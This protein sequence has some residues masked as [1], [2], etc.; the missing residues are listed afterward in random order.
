MTELSNFTSDK[1]PLSDLLK[2]IQAGKTQLPDFQRGWVWDNDHICSLLASISL[3]FPIGAV[4]L[5]QTGGEAKFKPRLIEG[6]VTNNGTEP[7]RLILDGQ[8]RLTSL[9]QALFS[10]QVVNTKDARGYPLKRWYYLDIKK[11]LDPVLDR[12]EAIISLPEDKIT[13]NFRGEAEKDYSTPEKEYEAEL[14]PLPLIFE[15]HALM[16]WQMRYIQSDPAK[17][18]E[19]MERWTNLLEKVLQAFQYYHVPTIVLKKNTPKE[20]VCKV[21]EKV[22]TGGVSL[23]VFELLTATY[24]ID[25]FNLR[26]D[27][28]EREKRLKGPANNK[29]L[30]KLQNTDFLQAVSLLATLDK[31]NKAIGAGKA[32]ENAPA[33]SCKRK[34]ILKLTLEEYKHWA[35]AATVGYEK[36]ARFLF[37]QKIFDAR[38]LPY[39]T[40]IVPLACILTLLGN[41]VEK[42]SI[43]NKVIQWYWC[44]VMGE[45]YGSAIETRFAKDLVEVLEWAK[46]GA[47]P[48]TFI[49]A[50]VVPA[51]LHSLR[52]RNSAAYKGLYALLMLDGVLDFR[53]GEEIDVD[54]Y[55]ENK[56]DIHHIFPQKWC[57][58]QG[59]EPKVFN[60]VINK[61]PLSARTNRIIGGRA[62]SAYLSRVQNSAGIDEARMDDI[63]STH[64]I[65][66]SLLRADDFHAF[67][68][69]RQESLLQRIES[70]MGKPIARDSVLPAE[71]VIE[72]ADE[73]PEE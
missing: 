33:V 14:L 73:Q 35:D 30:A 2:S 50:S 10:K 37:T 72:N 61:T 28:R 25:E 55:F 21:F 7:E 71:D 18:T 17:S 64:Y 56:I 12:E 32:P 6:V 26:D 29:V 69:A 41:E 62:P 20:A 44:G 15:P 54:R 43:K 38:D 68:E 1:E 57:T 4:M 66:P 47:E 36:A 58:D 9:F 22:N 46:G 34:D 31:R 19:R 5:L 53:S 51:R 11:A 63:L 52:T 24:A 48:T 3:S 65:T 42:E 60:S 8:Q 39:Q 49:D 40:Q 67:F 16:Q 23:T 13:R 59:V 45:L 27:W 70:A